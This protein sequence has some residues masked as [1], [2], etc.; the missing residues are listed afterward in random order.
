MPHSPA[1]APPTPTDATGGPPVPHRLEHPG[2]LG[3]L[4]LVAVGGR[5]A[6]VHFTDE[7]HR[8]A[9]VELGVPAPA[10]GADAAV[11][12]AAAQQLD[13]YFAGT[14]TG[15]DLPLGAQGTDFQREVWALLQQVPYGTTTT[16]G[17]LAAAL[18]RAT[19]ARAVGAAVGRNPLGV[20]VPCH[21]VVGGNG[22]LT[23]YAGGLDRKLWLLGHEGVLTGA[24]APGAADGTGARGGT[25]VA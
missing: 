9:E 7:R 16:Y 13:D 12:R 19:A 14:R 11:L 10:E 3:P 2:P 20:V 18:G 6:G 17:A 15:F 24:E 23:G 1:A 5:L 4:T 8:P 22:S 21:R 25:S